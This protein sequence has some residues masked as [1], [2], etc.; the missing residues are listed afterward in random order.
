MNLYLHYENLTLRPFLRAIELDGRNA[1]Y[2]CNRAAAQ[3]KL[4]NHQ[5]AIDDCK[6]AIAIDPQYSKAYG[7]LGYSSFN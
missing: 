7:R 6:Q 3:S 1:V 4:N 2:Y 5:A